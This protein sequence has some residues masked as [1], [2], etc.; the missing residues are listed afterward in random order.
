M[1]SHD[2]KT[3]SMPRAG[4]FCGGPSMFYVHFLTTSL[5]RSMQCSSILM[6]VSYIMAALQYCQR[7]DSGT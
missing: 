1:P 6:V 7:P 5:Q 2:H 3:E 4:V